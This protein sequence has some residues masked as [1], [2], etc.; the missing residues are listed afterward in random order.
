MTRGLSGDF[1]DAKRI[2]GGAAVAEGLLSGWIF[3]GLGL[4]YS[5]LPQL[6]TAVEWLGAFALITVGL[7]FT[8]RG[9][10]KDISGQEVPDKEGAGFLL[11]FGLVLGNPGMIGTWGGALAALEGT[12]LVQASASGAIG[13]GFGVFVGVLGW[14][15]LMLRLIQSY[16]S[17]LNATAL[18]FAVR[19][20]GLALAIGGS[21][22]AAS[23]LGES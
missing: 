7:W 10:S 12:G 19:G 3:A 16:G 13:I 5:Q 22:S 11:G 21:I 14:F 18:N 20:I 9:V 15:L 1:K 6:E 17:A 23:L 4:L 8:L 2:A